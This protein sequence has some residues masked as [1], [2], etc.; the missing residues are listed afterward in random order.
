MVYER[1]CR[2][3]LFS[4]NKIV[5]DVRKAEV[6]ASAGDGHFTCHKASLIGEDVC[7]RGF[8]DRGLSLAARLATIL[9]LVEF[10]PLPSAGQLERGLR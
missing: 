6:I 9:G 1:C 4:A 7:C 5:S 8:Y 2:E 3:C 10:V